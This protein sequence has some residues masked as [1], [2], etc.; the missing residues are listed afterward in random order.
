[1]IWRL[2]LGLGPNLTLSVGETP[3]D[4]MTPIVPFVILVDV[5]FFGYI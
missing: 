5:S 1:M 4:A 3:E 2:L